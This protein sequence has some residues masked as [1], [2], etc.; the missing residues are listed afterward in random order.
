[1]GGNFLWE[2]TFVDNEMHRAKSKEE[3]KV[4]DYQLRE[5]SLHSTL[6]FKANKYANL[7]SGLL[8]SRRTTFSS[9]TRP[10]DQKEA[11]TKL[12]ITYHILSAQL[13]ARHDI[14]FKW[15]GFGL[16]LNVI[17]PFYRFATSVEA[18]YYE[19]GEKKFGGKADDLESGMND[20]KFF[21][22]IVMPVVYFAI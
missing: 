10:K 3:N 14:F 16:G 21:S 18:E 5:V 17:L 8:L 15:G 19:N 11:E 6:H 4:S 12:N 7:G 20:I 1:M 9:F 22:F 2:G 13:A